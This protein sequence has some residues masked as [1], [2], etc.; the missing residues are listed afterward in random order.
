[1]S[2]DGM[3]AGLMGS[4]NAGHNWH[5]DILNSWTPENTNTNVPVLDG[6]QNATTFS[7]KFLIGADFFNLR[8]ITLGYTFPGK[9]LNKASIERAR[10]YVNADNVALWSKRKG[11]D[12]RQYISGESAANYSTIRTVSVGLSL[13]F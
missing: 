3:Y 12:P 13:T 1:D 10:L 5:K 8:N 6:D 7:D 9:W 2:Y 4:S 11:M